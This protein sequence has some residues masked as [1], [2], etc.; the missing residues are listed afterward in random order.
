MKNIILALVLCFCFQ[1]VAHG[2]IYVYTY[3]DSKEIIFIE[4]KDNVV[5]SEYDKGNI[6]KTILPNNIEFYNLTEQHSDYKL[7]GKKIILNTKKISDR[8][9]EKVKIQEDKIK[10]DNYFESAKEKLIILG[11]TDD[12]VEALR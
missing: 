8:E 11:L 6:E 5:V 12:E 10:K 3:K 2:S 1:S 9:D 7:S 4:E